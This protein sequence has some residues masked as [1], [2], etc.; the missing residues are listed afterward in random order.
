[1]SPRPVVLNHIHLTAEDPDQE[2]RFLVE[3]LGF[4]KDPTH[5]GFAWLG[6]LQLAVTKGEPVTNPRFHMGFRMDGKE[7]VDAFRDSLREHGVESSEPFANGAYYSCAFASPSG[8]QFE[9]YADSGIPALGTLA[10]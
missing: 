4:R 9:L 6:T 2:L 5:P 8:Y 1:M 7:Q 3:V 10:E